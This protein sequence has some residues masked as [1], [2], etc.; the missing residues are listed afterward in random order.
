MHNVMCSVYQSTLTLVSLTTKKN[1]LLRINWTYNVLENVFVLRTNSRTYV[2]IE[3]IID[4]MLDRCYPDNPCLT[5]LSSWFLMIDQLSH[6]V[7]ITQRRC[8]FYPWFHYSTRST[9]MLSRSS[10]LPPANIASSSSLLSSCAAL[11]NSNFRLHLY[12]VSIFLPIWDAWI[13]LAHDCP[14]RRTC[15]IILS[16]E[17]H[18]VLRGLMSPDR[19]AICASMWLLMVT[20]NTKSPAS[21][22]ACAR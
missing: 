18:H 5:Y 8:N 12:L 20:S 6:V 15:S 7:V 22:Y 3:R 1:I 17:K 2:V 13:P 14:S 21:L 16:P 19:N 9:S 11:S 4:I 10:R